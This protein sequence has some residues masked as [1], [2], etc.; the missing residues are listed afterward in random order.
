MITLSS[1]LLDYVSPGYHLHKGYQMRKY[2]V[3]AAQKVFEGTPTRD[4]ETGQY[5]G[6]DRDGTNVHIDMGLGKTIIGLTAIADLYRWGVCRRPT[7]VLAPIK[8]CQTVWRQEAAQ[9]SHTRHL[10]I[11]DLLGNERDRA[12]T[13]ARAFNE[14]TG[15]RGYD[16]ILCNPEKL[17]WL[18]KYLRGK[19]EFFD[20]LVIDD[21][22]LKDPKSRQFKI[23]TNY[24]DKIAKVDPFTGKAAVPREYVKIPPHRFKRAA[25]LTGTPST[26]GL[27]N[28]WSPNYIMDHGARLMRDYGSFEAR[29]FHK[30]HQVAEHVHKMELNSEEDQA[31]PAYVA[32]TGAPERMHELIADIT[33]ELNAEDYGVLPATIGDASK[34]EPPRS[35]LHRVEL[36]SE[37]RAKYDQ[38]ER[39]AIIELA[40]NTTMA[41][42][43]GAKSMMCWQIANGAMYVEDQFGVKVPQE[44]HS[45]KLDKLVELIDTLN[46]NVIVPY[47]FQHDY[48]RI[49]ARLE[50]EKMAWASLKGRNTERVV[51]QWNAGNIPILL[52]H[53][54]SAGHGLN[55]QFGGHHL[56]WYSMLW[57][58]ERYLQTNARLA[59]SGQSGIV[60]IHHIVT[61]R[62]TDELMLTNLRQNGDDQQRFRAALR[63]YQ[64]LRGIDFI[65]LGD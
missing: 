58:L 55:L 45:V 49:V 15:V 4:A 47:Y 48:A 20:A 35:H 11:G 50:K 17:H 37:L 26:N 14:Q 23:L 61:S 18:I 28:L 32:R 13:L 9:W 54:Q 53:P 5:S 43:G 22:A 63:E 40:G 27:H 60:G 34:G 19:W 7:L 41:Q 52:L 44:L 30:G 8:V 51:N 56:V 33:I 10:R 6:A 46:A 25:K 59:R 2:Q 65:T 24:G 42:N 21:V 31:R 38:L 36:P 64:K 29:F 1:T 39:D 16:V 57:S 3:R 12:F 62:T